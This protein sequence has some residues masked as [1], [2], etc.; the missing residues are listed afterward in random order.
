[1]WGRRGQ[2]TTNGTPT[3]FS[4]HGPIPRCVS[5]SPDTLPNFLQNFRRETLAPLTPA[6]RPE[7]FRMFSL[8]TGAWI[9]CVGRRTISRVG[10]TTGRTRSRH[11]AAAFRL[12]WQ[13]V[14]NG[15]EVMRLLLVV[16][17]KTFIP[18]TR[19]GVVVDDTLCHQRGAKVAFG[20]IFLDA[21]L[22]SKRHKT[23]R[24]GNNGVLLGLVVSMPFR[25]D[26]FF[27]LP[28]LWRVYQKQGSKPKADHR[29]KPELAA[30]A[31]RTLAEWL[32]GRKILVV[33]DSA[34]I[35]KAMLHGRP[36]D[37]E[38]IGPICWHAARTEVHAGPDGVEGDSGKRLPT[39]RAILDDDRNGPPRTRWFD[40]PNGTRKRLHLK[41]VEA[42]WPTVTG[43]NRVAVVL[44]RDPK[45]HWR[46][47]AL[48]STNPALC[49]WDIVV[50][51]CWSVEVAIG[52]AKGLLGFHDP[53]VWKK[54]SVRRA[55]PMAWF[56]GTLVML[57]YARE[58]AD[59]RPA[60]RHRR[61]YPKTVTTF[62]DL[63]A[64]CRLALWEQKWS[65]RGDR[66]PVLDRDEG[67]LVEYLATAA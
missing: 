59:H 57:W 49:D 30:D 25:R 63:L 28:L 29:T 32:P 39:L 14:W 2:N 15:D 18:G 11:H 34:S 60:R 41:W 16:I 33:A 37:V 61:W 53:C 56:T 12:F 4:G 23:F 67:G 50:G 26:R 35:G 10:E 36:E 65:G 5:G 17:V 55:A 54:E 13:A 7:V 8:M 1:M 3:R 38:S 46:D 9:A 20:G 6:F 27:C 44:L 19:V 24:F 42:C 52:D 62:A 64:C 45:G 51:Y 43:G 21:V 48:V 31:V 47:E 66:C 22:S 58:R 40:L